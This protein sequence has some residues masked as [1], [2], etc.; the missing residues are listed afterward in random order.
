MVTVGGNNRLNKNVKEA[1]R[2]EMSLR[3][4]KMFNIFLK[5]RWP[6]TCFGL[7]K[8]SCKT[9]WG[10]KFTSLAYLEISCNQE[11]RKSVSNE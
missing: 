10:L 5:S 6:Y 11:V 2:E 4:W 3:V 9:F 7:Y 8:F 1:A